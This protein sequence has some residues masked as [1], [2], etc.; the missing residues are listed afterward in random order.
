MPHLSAERPPCPRQLQR[1]RH[2]PQ[3]SL[4]WENWTPQPSRGY[5][6][7]FIGDIGWNLPVFLQGLC[8]TCAP[9]LSCHCPGQDSAHRHCLAREVV[10][11][12]ASMSSWGGNYK[13]R[14]VRG[15]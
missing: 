8:A 11:M 12:N 2:V 6:A 10:T 3:L 14:S 9:C 7:Q 15:Q 5:Y 13:G 1:L 4:K